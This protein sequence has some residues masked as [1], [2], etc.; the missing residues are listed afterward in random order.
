MECTHCGNQHSIQ[1]SHDLV[2]E[3]DYH[4]TLRL[5]PQASPESIRM[6]VECHACG[7]ETHFNENIHA[8]ECPFCGTQFVLATKEH[9]VIE[10]KSLL[11]FVI[12][13]DEAKQHYK[14]W[15]KR[16]W[17]A[18]NKI[19]KYAKQDKVLHGVYVP[20]WTYDCDTFTQYSGERG[21]IH[22]VQRSV[23]VQIN[24]RW[25][26]QLQMVP[27]VRWSPARGRVN[28]HF[29]D[30]LIY[31]SDTLP[32]ELSREL[33]PWD[34]SNLRPYQAEFLS[35][36]RS[37]V[38]RTDLDAGFTIAQ[39]RLSPFIRD[40]IQRDIGGDQQRIHQTQ[41]QYDNVKFKHCLLP[42]WVAGF[43][44]RNKTYQFVVNGRTGEV[45]GDR[46][47]SYLKL[48]LTALGALTLLV[49]LMS[50]T[51]ESGRSL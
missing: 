17:F 49:L 1:A 8:D 5:L 37:E 51:L 34:L 22:H 39:R 44:F 32:R 28:N 29:D 36:F 18:P 33:A 31:A 41:T 4:A 43:R 38:Y 47:W 10:P 14:A 24:G 50:L 2:H 21:D 35:G 42:F 3:Y 30:T 25:T 23:R 13:D 26:T 16:L 9:R 6:T 7:A 48:A 11:P 19:K 46:P 45:Q 15:I 27:E 20:Y 12:T 40:T